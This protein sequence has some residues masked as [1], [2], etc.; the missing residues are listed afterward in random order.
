MK[1]IL[2]F[3]S[4]AT[5]NQAL[6][7]SA[8]PVSSVNGTRTTLTCSYSLNTQGYVLYR[9]LWYNSDVFVASSIMARFSNTGTINP[10]YFIGYDSSTHTMTRDDSMST[11]TF[12]EVNVYNDDRVYGCTVEYRKGLDRESGRATTKLTVIGK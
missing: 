5:S 9:V 12:A 6:Q 11:F 3:P 8:P 2:F 10:E 7:V 4:P 1:S